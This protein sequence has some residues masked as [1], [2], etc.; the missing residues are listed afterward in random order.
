MEEDAEGRGRKKG[1]EL[2]L[3]RKACIEA[4]RTCIKFKRKKEEKKCL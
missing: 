1:K 2:K 4:E 3:E